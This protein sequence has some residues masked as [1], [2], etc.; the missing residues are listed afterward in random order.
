[1]ASECCISCGLSLKNDSDLSTRNGNVFLNYGYSSE[2]DGCS[3]TFVDGYRWEHGRRYIAYLP[4]DE[5]KKLY[6]TDGTGVCDD[7]TRSLLKE[8]R[9]RY[10]NDVDYDFYIESNTKCDLCAAQWSEVRHDLQST[11]FFGPEQP[12]ENHL[13]IVVRETGT[14]DGIQFVHYIHHIDEWTPE[15]LYWRY[16]LAS[17]REITDNM[18]LCRCCTSSLIQQGCLVSSAYIEDNF[19][20]M[21]ATLAELTTFRNYVALL[22]SPSPTNEAKARNCETIAQTDAKIRVVTQ[23]EG[24]LASIR[25]LAVRDLPVPPPETDR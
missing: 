5:V 7:C 6:P 3:Y 20:K 22:T 19:P 13:C 1:M 23:R 2:H 15:V 4:E 8:G 12:I 9:L 24:F 10:T 25:S 18:V 14:G 16:G 11:S 17:S 21:G